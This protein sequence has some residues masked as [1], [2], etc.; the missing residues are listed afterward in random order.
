MFASRPSGAVSPRRTP[1]S[2]FAGNDGTKDN[3]P[4]IPSPKNP[5]QSANDL[6]DDIDALHGELSERDAA[7][8]QK[9]AG[10][11][12]EDLTQ[13]IDL[14]K[15]ELEK[16]RAAQI[17][18][19]AFLTLSSYVDA[20][21]SGDPS[22]PGLDLILKLTLGKSPLSEEQKTNLR[23]IEEVHRLEG[24]LNDLQRALDEYPPA[25]FLGFPCE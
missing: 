21:E 22:M 14:T 5:F 25:S 15:S 4:A 6:I 19:R 3:C 2:G 7:S 17:D 10:W 16:A 18:S 12:E 9:A 11:T 20:L 24:H 8:S 23:D 13:L 1:G